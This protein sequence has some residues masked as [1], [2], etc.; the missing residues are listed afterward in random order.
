MLGGWKGEDWL[1][2]VSAQVIAQALPSGNL[3]LHVVRVVGM[4]KK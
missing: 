4:G 2:K 3:F 1:F